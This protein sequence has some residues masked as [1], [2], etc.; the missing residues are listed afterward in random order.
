MD[1]HGT[2]NTAPYLYAP[3]HAPENLVT[4]EDDPEKSSDQLAALLAAGL[5]AGQ[6][7]TLRGNLSR[8]EPDVDDPKFHAIADA[9]ERLTARLLTD[10]GYED[11]QPTLASWLAQGE[12]GMV[13]LI[14]AARP[15][16]CAHCGHKVEAETE[17]EV[18][19]GMRAHMAVCPD[20]P[21][22]LVERQRDDALSALSSLRS[23]DCGACGSGVEFRIAR[24]PDD[25]AHRQAVDPSF[26]Y[27]C[28]VCSSAEPVEGQ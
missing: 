3:D 7:V 11:A 9:L 5:V 15:L 2:G 17:Q 19:D 22:R 12:A 27:Y 21:M 28:P 16:L 18:E 25:G 23:M 1:T 6:L 8:Q 20:H 13:P 14:G 24:E 10:S 26:Y 4:Y